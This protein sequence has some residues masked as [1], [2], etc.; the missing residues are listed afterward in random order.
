M[1]YASV[2]LFGYLFFWLLCISL[3][4]KDIMLVVFLVV[5]RLSVYVRNN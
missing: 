2:Y 5:M 4:M 3:F 1:F